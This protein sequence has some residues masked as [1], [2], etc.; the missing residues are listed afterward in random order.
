MRRP[1]AGFIGQISLAGR[2]EKT[3][4]NRFRV[5]CRKVQNDLFT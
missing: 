5:I 4:D 1:Q 3:A 2:C